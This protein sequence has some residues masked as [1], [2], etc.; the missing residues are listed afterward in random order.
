MNFESIKDILRDEAERREIAQYEIF[1]T[2]SKSVSTETLENEISSFAA[3][4]GAGVN[5]RCVRE[6][7]MGSA[8][9]ELFT[10]D[11]L[12]GL[13]ARAFA[14]AGVIEN[15]D[16]A[17][18]F[19][20]SDKYAE[21]DCKATDMPAAA[22]VKALALDIQKRTYAESELVTD[23]TQSGVFAQ[24][25]RYELVN[26]NGL[27]LSNTVSLTGAF[28]QAVVSRD[29]EAQEAF[30]FSLGFDESERIS[31]KAVDNAI[32]KLGA[33]DIPSGKYDVIIDGKQ[34]RSML[35]AFAS[36]FSGKNALLG[37][38]LL[39]GK[40]GE[41]VAAECVTLVDDPLGECNP[42]PTPFDGEGVATFEKNVIENGTLKTLLYDIA[43]AHKADKTTTANGQ[44]GSYSEQVHIEP[45]C[46][47][48]K[49]GELTDDELLLSMGNGI[50]VT[51]LKGLHA[52]ANS[53]TGDFSIES[54]GYL[55][56][57]GRITKAV[58]GFT[59]AGNFFTLLKDIKA[60]GSKV[61]FGLPS[62]FTTYGSPSVYL[63]DM[64]IAGQ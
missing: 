56:E 37:L 59:V 52:G 53:V 23:G 6:G 33:V 14:N 7:H 19:C 25:E 58:K 26:S 20:G 40:E 49:G 57:S 51:E 15:N 42:V 64:S 43:T 63:T 60:V 32:S 22:D 35:S 10:E 48:I 4:T 30:E 50:Y 54:A 39:A 46:F 18:I 47:Y 8:S 29:G 3:G 13:V 44:R 62:G 21:C 27:N 45:F 24:T 38:S 2:E 1:F 61:K 17:V 41:R 9:T 28:V 5:F 11:E 31:K 34:M 12:R 55:V 16:V 36:A